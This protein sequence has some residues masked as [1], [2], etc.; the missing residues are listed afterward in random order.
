MA[1]RGLRKCTKLCFKSQ[2]TSFNGPKM[3]LTADETALP[4]LPTI[5]LPKRDFNRRVGCFPLKC[6][7]LFQSFKHHQEK[8]E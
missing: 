5:S 3:A 4:Y 6:E 7:L 2:I 1:T 8:R